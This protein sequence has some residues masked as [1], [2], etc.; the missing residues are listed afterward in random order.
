MLERYNC[1]YQL[2]ERN[3]KAQ[4]TIENYALAHAAGDV[5]AGL[6]MGLVPGGGLI[7]TIGCIAAQG[8]LVYQPM[9]RELARI[10]QARPDEVTNAI[11]VDAWQTGAIGDIA[12]EFVGEFFMEIAPDLAREIGLGGVLGAIPLLGSVV[13]ATLDAIIAATLTWRVGTMIS[14]YYQNGERW[15]ESRHHTYKLTKPMTGW[16]PNPTGRVKLDDIPQQCPSVKE[17][18]IEAARLVVEMLVSVC[19]DKQQ[20]RQVLLKKGLPEFLVSE[21]IR[22]FVG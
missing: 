1:L 2:P 12:A 22:R 11:I 6:L 8:P 4:Q 20:I 5:A 17:G 16:S 19:S 3:L 10:Y 9:A 7:A 15:V 18:Q 14:M 13:S 21:A